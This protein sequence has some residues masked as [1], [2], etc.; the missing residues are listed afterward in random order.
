MPG[1]RT[2]IAAALAG[3]LAATGCCS[4]CQRHCPCAAAPPATGTGGHLAIDG[5]NL[6]PAI[7]RITL[8][9]VSVPMRQLYVSALYMRRTTERIV[10]ELETADGARG[11]GDVQLRQ[12]VGHTQRRCDQWRRG[13]R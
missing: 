13:R 7:T 2:W 5:A 4:W 6:I 3:L 12:P 8:H 10:V 1:K 11:F 9:S